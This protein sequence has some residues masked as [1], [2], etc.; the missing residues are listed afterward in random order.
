MVINRNKERREEDLKVVLDN[1]KEEVKARK[2]K[3]TVRFLGVL[4]I[5]KSEK[6][7]QN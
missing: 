7:L 4:L 3:D 5:I 1:K 2:V 6:S